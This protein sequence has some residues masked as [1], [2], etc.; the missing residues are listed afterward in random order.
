MSVTLIWLPLIEAI[1][2]LKF[3]KGERLYLAIDRTQWSD[4]NLFMIAVI[5]EKRAVPIYWQ[6]LE[7][8]G[9]SNLVEQQALIRPV[10]KLLKS[11][12]LVVL[13][14]REFYSVERA[15]CLKSNKVYLVLRQKKDTCIQEKG[16]NYQ[17]LDSLDITPGVKRFLTGLKARKE[18]GFSKGAIGI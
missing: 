5:I 15:K 10:L 16:K 17:R 3:T 7:K 11:Y 1:I 12:E 14:D 8:K 2:K 9:A 13:G 4:K 6:F 18:K